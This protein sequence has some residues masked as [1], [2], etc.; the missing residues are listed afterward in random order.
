MVETKFKGEHLDMTEA[1]V[2]SYKF[3]KYRFE[4][5]NEDSPI[6]YREQD[7]EEVRLS[8]KE[9]QV[10][11]FLIKNRDKY[12]TAGELI[13][14]CWEKYAAIEENGATQIIS[15]L[16]KTL[17][18][19][20][21]NNKYI[22]TRDR[23]IQTLD[24]KKRAVAEYRFV[25]EIEKIKT[26]GDVPTPQET[27]PSVPEPDIL[28]PSEQTLNNADDKPL[29]QESNINPFLPENIPAD[30]L[31]PTN[32]EP[33]EGLETKHEETKVEPPENEREIAGYSKWQPG[34]LKPA[35]ESAT[36]KSREE[37]MKF[38]A[39]LSGSGKAITW[40][41]SVCVVLTFLISLW[42]T[43]IPIKN[44][45]EFTAD[46]FENPQSLADKLT[47]AQKGVISAYL[48][49]RDKTVSESVCVA[50]PTEQSNKQLSENLKSIFNEA[51]KD[52]FLYNRARFENVALSERSDQLIKQGTSGDLAAL[53]RSILQDAYLTEIR[54]NANVTW[55]KPAAALLQCLTIFIIL[56]YARKNFQQNDF[57]YLGSNKIDEKVKNSLQKIRK[58]WLWLFLMWLLLYLVLF[59]YYAEE[60]FHLNNL[61]SVT[62]DRF[63]LGANLLFTFFNYVNTIIIIYCFLYLNEQGE[64]DKESKKDRFMYRNVLIAF[65]I[66]TLFFYAISAPNKLVSSFL[67]LFTG[68]VAGIAMALFIGRLQSKFLGTRPLH[69]II[70]YSYMALQPLYY[71]LTSIDG[72]D[73]ATVLLIN[74]YLISKCFLFL[75]M[76]WLF[77]S[78]RL[79]FY[80][81]E[82][83]EKHKDIKDN[84]DE[85]MDKLK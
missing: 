79:A 63:T 7:N 72:W 68:I 53:N 22:Q 15:K 5:K 73:F 28:E 19:Q 23:K 31:S 29:N 80:L 60:I 3:G 34:N 27:I 36:V 46:D 58:H 85:W 33:N 24:K 47:A 50:K 6:L 54:K 39:W 81:A 13:D 40:I 52:K 4:T 43:R 83:K 82:I 37:Y 78:T 26:L 61:F 74:L 8:P 69:I 75:Y 21:R 51:L 1:A 18:G 76:V 66:L 49:E 59:F 25:A 41:L 17:G 14:E 77:E 45:Q 62:P 11:L 38:G 48:C 30:Q 42:L 16:R 44:S 65:G 70:L 20:A 12:Y 84:W 10:L 64:T 57:S 2:E 9:Q 67:D 71:L 55:G 56:L 35:G 32:E